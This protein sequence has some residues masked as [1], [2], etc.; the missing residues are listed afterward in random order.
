MAALGSFGDRIID[1]IRDYLEDD[2]TPPAIRLELPTVL[3]AMATPAA[4][5]VLADNVLT[6]DPALRMRVLAALNK[7]AQLY[8][9]R[10]VQRPLVETALEA[11]ITGHYRSYQVLDAIGGSLAGAEPVVAGL[12]EALSQESERIFRLMK[13]LYPA[14]DM[15]SAFVGIQSDQPAVHDNALEFLDTV[16]PPALR[17]LVV[18]LFDREVDPAGRA[19][20]AER[21]VGVTVGSRDEAV[22]V[23][24]RSRDP[25][26]QACAAYAIGELRLV[27]LAH[28]VDA[29][30]TAADPLL[31]TT[32][33]AARAKLK[34]RA[35][36]PSV[37][38]G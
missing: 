9:E 11:E 18:P 21:V 1:P 34:G 17:A 35:V 32:A 28:Q 4:H 31:R 3:Q 38:V 10:R 23:L 14:H 15:H 37:D 25:W 20:A 5:A 12:R 26:L 8:P 16:L 2:D 13:I 27:S 30:S 22:E 7:L 29:W 24:A 6:G 33:D 19:R 36:M